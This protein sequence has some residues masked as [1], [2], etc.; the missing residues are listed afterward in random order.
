MNFIVS[1]S[2]QDRDKIEELLRQLTGGQVSI[3]NIKPYTGYES[4]T[5]LSRRD[6]S[7]DEKYD[8]FK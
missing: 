5:D 7:T 3:R 1:G 4:G 8:L 2:G 6:A